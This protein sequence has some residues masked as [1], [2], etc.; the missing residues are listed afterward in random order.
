MNALTL[1]RG[2][3]LE[4][5]GAHTLVGREALTCP[6]IAA[7][8]SEVLKKTVTYTGHDTAPFE[9][10]LAHHAPGWM[11]MDLRL[12]LD[13]FGT[14]G[15]AASASDVDKMTALLGRTRRT[16]AEFAVE[17]IASWTAQ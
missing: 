6:R 14:D 5:C 4:V 9:A 8:W 17:T 3:R 1:A 15:M 16:Y 13:R 11:A 10:R 7:V 12:M 2:S